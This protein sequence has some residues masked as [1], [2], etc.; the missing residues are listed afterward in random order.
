MDP[1]AGGRARTNGPRVRAR[2]A[3]G[4]LTSHLFQIRTLASWD[5]S[6]QGEFSYP[7]PFGSV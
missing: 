5:P 4:V 1:P 2:A 3:G 7:E 6:V